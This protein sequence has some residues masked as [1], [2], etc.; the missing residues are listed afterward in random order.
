MDSLEEESPD[1]AQSY[2]ENESESIPLSLDKSNKAIKDKRMQKKKNKHPTCNTLLSIIFIFIILLLI[3]INFYKIINIKREDEGI[4]EYNNNTNYSDINLNALYN[5]TINIAFLYSSLFGNGIGRFMIVTGEYLIRKGYNVYFLTKSPYAK[6]FKFNKKIKRLYVYHNWTLIRKAIK[7]EKI[8]FLII[9]NVF[10]LGMIKEYKSFGVKV[11]GI[12][13][14]IYMSGMFNNDTGIYKLW[15][16]LDYLDAYIHINSDDYYFF[17]SYGFKRNIFIP[18]LYTFNP[19]EVPS[20]NL[21]NHNIMMLGR[22]ND[23]K[24]GVEYALKALKL[25][26]EEVPDARLNM[27]SSDSRLQEY[28]NLSRELN[29]TN[30]AFFS[31]YVENITKYFMNSSIFLFTSLTEAFPM[32]LNEAKAYG[33]PCVTFDISYSIP[34]QSGVISVEMFD[35]KALARE[36][37]KLLKDYDYRIKK[38]KEAKLSL[39]KFK[40]EDTANLWTRLFYSLLKGD[41][42]FQKFRMETERKYFNEKLAKKHFIKQLEYVKIYNKNFKC[43]SLENFA[44]LTYVNNIKDCENV[45]RRRRGRRRR[46]N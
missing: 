16:N 22:L 34:F 27:I 42:E 20:S 38:G 17:K 4:N 14:G 28:K 25:I 18:N 2:K 30:N 9:N 33:L 1:N 36:S 15:K 11:I 46:R 3:S 12:F 26:I 10:D 35:Y 31:L 45:T 23:K 8:D 32:A 43:H 19:D 13:H 40:N 44:N 29:L 41:Y 6:D 37:I 7:E 39:N 21:T 5:R 24:K